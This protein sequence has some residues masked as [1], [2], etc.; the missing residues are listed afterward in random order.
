MSLVD[1]PYLLV[2]DVPQLTTKACF[3]FFSISIL[4]SLL[5]MTIQIQT[6]NMIYIIYI[7]AYIFCVFKSLSK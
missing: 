3:H 5:A 1:F 4:V 6:Y 7:Y 2:K